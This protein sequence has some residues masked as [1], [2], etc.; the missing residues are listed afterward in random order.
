MTLQS[1]NL[2]QLRPGG[3]GGRDEEDGGEVR[4]LEGGVCMRMEC[5][6][7]W[8]AVLL[9]PPPAPPA[10]TISRRLPSPPAIGAKRGAMRWDTIGGNTPARCQTM[11]SQ[12]TLPHFLV[13]LLRTSQAPWVYE[14][15]APRP[16]S[17]A[18]HPDG[19]AGHTGHQLHRPPQ[20]LPPGR[21]P[22]RPPPRRWL[23]GTDLSRRVTP[24]RAHGWARIG[25]PTHTHL[26]Q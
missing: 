2:D 20:Q 5:G 25:A 21:R 9:P 26:E 1:Q 6:C 8:E 16:P 14:S 3:K 18:G 24:C 7:G 4:P 23:G 15:P 13:C 12:R 10:P 17:H 22:P 19:G 11:C